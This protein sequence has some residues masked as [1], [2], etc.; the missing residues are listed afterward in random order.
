MVN[1]TKEQ[2]KELVVT[3]GETPTK[4]TVEKLASG[5]GKSVSF[6]FFH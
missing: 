6:P 3:Y 1:Y 4:A 5:M 2:V